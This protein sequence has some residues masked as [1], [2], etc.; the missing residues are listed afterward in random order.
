[1]SS[2][3]SFLRISVL[4]AATLTVLSAHASPN[5]YAFHGSR[6]GRT[7]N[8][9]HTLEVGTVAD[10]LEYPRLVDASGIT[11]CDRYFG[12][13]GQPATPTEELKILCGKYQFFFEHYGAQGFPKQLYDF[14]AR[15]YS[16]FLGDEMEKLGLVPNPELGRD[17][18]DVTVTPAGTCVKTK[19]V[20]DR[21]FLWWC[22]SE[23][24][25]CVQRTTRDEYAERYTVVDTHLP[26]GVVPSPKQ[27]F[28]MDAYGMTCAACHTSMLPDGRFAV[29]MGANRMNYGQ[30]ILGFQG[31]LQSSLSSLMALA[32]ATSAQDLLKNLTAEVPELGELTGLLDLMQMHPD[33]QFN[34]PSTKLALS[35]AGYEAAMA[36]L[37]VGTC[38]YEDPAR[39]RILLCDVN[40]ESKGPLARRQAAARLRQR[41][42]RELGGVYTSDWELPFT[43]TWGDAYCLPA[44]QR[45]SWYGGSN[46]SQ[47][48]QYIPG[49]L[50]STN[51]NR[52]AEACHGRRWNWRFWS[53]FT[54]TF[55]DLVQ[56][57]GSGGARIPV[58]DLN[59]QSNF[60]VLAHGT[61]DFLTF[62]TSE[63]SV[64]TV[65]KMPSLFGMPTPAE[66]AAHPKMRR[67]DGSPT[68]VLGLAGGSAEAFDFVQSFPLIS[69][70]VDPRFVKCDEPGIAGHWSAVPN[71]SCRV[72]TE[73]LEPLAAYLRSLRTPAPVSPAP[74]M[75]PAEVVAGRATF[76]QRCQ[77]CHSGPQGQ[78]PGIFAFS[79]PGRAGLAPVPSCDAVPSV[80]WSDGVPRAAIYNDCSPSYKPD[81]MPQV[82][83][84][85]DT[86]PTYSQVF[87]PDPSTGESSAAE[88]NSLDGTPTEGVKGQRLNGV[89]YTRALLH[90]GKVESLGELLCAAGT[91]RATAWQRQMGECMSY[92]LST[93]ADLEA[94]RQGHGVCLHVWYPMQGHEFGCD[95]SDAERKALIAYL[96]TL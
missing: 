93:D 78:T 57:M 11:A 1:M 7:D 46:N 12:W 88:L 42:E 40:H 86:D 51:L 24:K 41:F 33:L 4:A 25:E 53:D 90:H 74:Q 34:N 52:A 44:P 8:A 37:K 45:P 50:P 22:Q 36:D 76:E 67:G 29:G 47:W 9:A 56:R 5:P 81:R 91:R 28:G 54:K 64:F 19:T 79:A 39:T 16:E 80:Q 31:P 6:D 82:L 20:C 13:N 38:Y 94:Y 89:A 92:N 68:Q 43:L 55:I 27:V 60:T 26:I 10:V 69:Q 14:N 2:L 96:E 70:S 15:W 62:P 23:H 18:T 59:A 49:L 75:V 71:E 58:I 85:I 35:G 73:T 95:M 87:D 48:S 72:K 63:D 32:E 84:Y 83:G 65:S 61:L 17:V 77:Q 21:W 30:I 66:V 3:Q